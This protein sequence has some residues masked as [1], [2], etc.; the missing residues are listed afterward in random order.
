M[1]AQVEIKLGGMSDSH[2]NRGACRYVS[3]LAA[4]LFLVGAEQSRVMPL[5]H[6]N[7]RDT[8]FVV[9]LQFNA[10]LTDS[11]QFVLQKLKELA[12]RDAIP[13]QYYPVRFVS[14]SGLVE[15]DEQFAGEF[16]TILL[17]LNDFGSLNFVE[18]SLKTCKHLHF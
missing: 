4:L 5:L 8:R 12:F 16:S 11:G 14:T 10:S 1:T 2:I 13:V 18:V 7:E 9:R 3:A 6:N 17:D 15:H